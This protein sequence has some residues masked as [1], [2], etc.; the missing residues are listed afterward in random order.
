MVLEN[1]DVEESWLSELD[2]I[3]LKML[4][5][6]INED[7][8]LWCITKPT[9]K[10]P[11]TV[12]RSSIKLTSDSPNGLRS[13]ALKHFSTEPLANDKFFSCA[14]GENSRNF[15]LKSVFSLVIFHAVVN[16]RKQYGSIGWNRAYDFGVNDFINCVLQFRQ[17]IKQFGEISSEEIRNFLNINNYGGKVTDVRDQRLLSS[18]L[19]AFFNENIQKQENYRFFESSDIFIPTEPNKSNSFDYVTGLGRKGS[20]EDVGLHANTDI[21]RNSSDVQQV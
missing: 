6:D 16:E 3:H 21:L 2:K 18:L 9:K 4:N 10:F 11:I 7:F 17:T 5:T 8:R 19:R 15:W 20:A 1:C 12:I 13:S 14:F